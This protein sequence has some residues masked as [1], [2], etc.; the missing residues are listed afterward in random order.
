MTV[1]HEGGGDDVTVVHVS[2]CSDSEMEED[3]L[4]QPAHLPDHHNNPWLQS[5]APVLLLNSELHRKTRE[6][7]V[8]HVKEGEM[9]VC[10]L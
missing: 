5:S 3:S 10:V 4:P 7:G 1:V 9:V 8:Q 6:E 2:L